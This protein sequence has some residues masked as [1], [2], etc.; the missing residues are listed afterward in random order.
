MVVAM[1]KPQ[2]LEFKTHQERSQWIKDNADYWTIVHHQ[3]YGKYERHERHTQD[4]AMKLARELA[5][6]RDCIWM[7]YAVAGNSD[8]YVDMVKPAHW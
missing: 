3:G 2:P 4:E 8:T 7:I 5:D 6:T 1:T